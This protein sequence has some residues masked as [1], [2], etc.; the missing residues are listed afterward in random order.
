MAA[1]VGLCALRR[2]IECAFG[3]VGSTLN[4]TVSVEDH[5]LAWAVVAMH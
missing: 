5:L 4:Q 3:C 1:T 2:F